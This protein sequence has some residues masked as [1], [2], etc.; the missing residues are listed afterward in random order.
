MERSAKRNGVSLNSELV[1]R[2][3]L[4]LHPQTDSDLEKRIDELRYRV[5]D[6]ESQRELLHLTVGMAA[7]Y[8]RWLMPM[9]RSEIREADRE[10]LEEVKIKIDSLIEVFGQAD[11]D[12][13]NL[14]HENLRDT[15]ARLIS[16]L[17]EA[18]KAR[19]LAVESDGESSSQ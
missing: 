7:H 13:V 5:A 11:E 2:L 4:T 16:T 1:D 10:I 9:L 18:R 6:L 17:E 15:G 12:Q 8:A 3:E 14:I 19:D